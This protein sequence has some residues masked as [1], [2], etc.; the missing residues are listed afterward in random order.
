MVLIARVRFVCV[1]FE[2]KVARCQ[3]KCHAGN[4]PDIGG[5]GVVCSQNHF[6]ATV[7]AGLNVGREV[8]VHPARVTQVSKLHVWQSH[9]G[10]LN[11]PWRLHTFHRGYERSTLCRGR[12]RFNSGSLTA[13]VSSSPS[14]VRTVGNARRTDAYPLFS[15]HLLCLLT[16]PQ[17]FFLVFG[18][19]FRGWGST[20]SVIFAKESFSY[21]RHFRV[22]PGAKSGIEGA[23][24]PDVQREQ[25][26]LRLNISVNDATVIM[27]RLKAHQRLPD[28]SAHHVHRNS[29]VVVLLDYSK[30]I[31]TKDLHYH[32][33]VLSVWT[34]VHEI[35]VQ[36]NNVT[37]PRCAM[38]IFSYGTQQLHLILSSLCVVGGT[39]ND[40]EGGI[41]VLLLVNNE[42]HGG[43]MA[44]AKLFQHLVPPLEDIS[45][46]H[47][48]VPALAVVLRILFRIR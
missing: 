7:L 2:E 8:L 32:A 26:V 16:P 36:E 37:S 13:R 15:L 30:Q 45:N 11:R 44:P 23:F 29:F 10:S 47:T 46:P 48:M 19:L 41:L 25:D 28:D 17:I 3:L 39:F 33:H 5:G 12:S 22:A 24:I 18:E 14:P 43:E 40:L 27:Q 9:E 20:S 6:N 35:I 21:V 38:I 4:T 34:V 42:P 31:R 1:G